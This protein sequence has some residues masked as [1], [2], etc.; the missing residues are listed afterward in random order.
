MVIVISDR[1]RL[2]C[3]EDVR[4]A[5][6]EWLTRRWP[7]SLIRRCFSLWRTQDFQRAQGGGITAFDAQLLKNIAEVLLHGFFCHTANDG[8]VAIGLAL[9]DPEEH[10][11][12][13]RGQ[14]E[15][16]QRNR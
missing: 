5:K 7:F 13:P 2:P 14:A 15:F 6:A 12:F 8:D 16:L 9:S 11:G 3:E 1:R 10:F 4:S